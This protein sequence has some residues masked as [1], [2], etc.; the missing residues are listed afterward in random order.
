MLRIEG[1]HKSFVVDKG[2]VRAVQNVSIDIKEGEFFTLLGPSGSGKSTTLR[3]VAGLEHPEAGEIYIGGECVFSAKRRILVPPEDRPIGMVFQSYAI[4]PHMDVFHNVAFP[5][6]YGARGKK[7]SKAEVE[8]NVMDALKMVQMAGL[9]HRPATQLSGGQQQ[10]VALA[11]AL[12]RKPK[13]LLLDEPLSNL[14]AKLRE[15]MRVELKEVTRSVG[16]TTFFVTHDQLEAL[17]LS[18]K[19]G[20]IMAGELVEVGSPY[21][22]YVR[23]KNK[24]VAEFLGTANAL[25][26]RVVRTGTEGAVETELGPI[27]VDLSRT[28]VGSNESVFVVIRP[29]GLVCSREPTG[30]ANNL[31]EG[32]IKRALF[33]GNFIDGEV[34]IKNKSFR[35][36]LSPYQAFHPGEKV[37][38]HVP[39]D[40]CQVTR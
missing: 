14:D 7:Y 29:E 22:M 35:A 37:Y 4:W 39:P 18:D 15:E 40:R 25:Q 20:V 1:L 38:V 6:L 36:L 30:I 2:Q 9:E 27:N 21:E 23:P 28:E 34:Q 10:R 13:L 24:L 16:I 8:K 12:V 3:C 33:L 32:T 31:F 11:R 26:G 17:A 19:I 5:L